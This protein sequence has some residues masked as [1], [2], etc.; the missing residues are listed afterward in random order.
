MSTHNMFLLKNKEEISDS[1]F[2]MKKGP[3]LLL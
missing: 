1:I 2:W 3:Y